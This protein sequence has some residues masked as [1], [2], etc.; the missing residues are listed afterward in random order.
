M[1]SPYYIN[2]NIC[3]RLTMNSFCF[4]P[5]SV[6]PLTVFVICWFKIE[7]FPNKM[8][9][10]SAQNSRDKP[11]FL[12]KLTGFLPQFWIVDH[13]L[14][15]FV[16]SSLHLCL[17]CTVAQFQSST[18]FHCGLPWISSFTLP[19]YPFCPRHN[20][21]K[22]SLFVWVLS[23]SNNPYLNRHMTWCGCHEILIERGITVRFFLTFSLYLIQRW[24][25]WLSYSN[26]SFQL[27]SI[28]RSVRQE[29]TSLTIRNHSFRPPMEGRLTLSDIS[30]VVIRTSLWIYCN[31][32]CTEF[33][34]IGEI[35]S[36]RCS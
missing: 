30:P 10:S 16:C 4:S 13:T 5:I 25:W 22:R 17:S 28:Q 18:W 14:S 7:E 21:R 32:K 11:F 23:H 15:C 3:R 2:Q 1:D 26:Q 20:S 6:Q 36:A 24:F 8:A 34:L 29:T 31:W 19:L 35:E 27:I 12:R 33:S 9:I